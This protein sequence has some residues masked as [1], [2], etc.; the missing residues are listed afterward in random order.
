M[1]LSVQMT[2][3]KNTHVDA[4]DSD[5]CDESFSFEI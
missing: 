2:W 3:V 1:V 4:V 5:G